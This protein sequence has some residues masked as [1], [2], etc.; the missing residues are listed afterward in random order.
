MFIQRLTKG[1]VRIVSIFFSA[2]SVKSLNRC[3][4]TNS[5]GVTSD[6]AAVVCRS[7]GCP[8]GRTSPFSRALEAL[9]SSKHRNYNLSLVLIGDIRRVEAKLL[10][11]TAMSTISL[12]QVV[13][14]CVKIET[15]S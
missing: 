13:H 15:K 11:Q 5:P 14:R 10:G 7:G 6:A 4:K 2:R 12:R 9:T 8:Q 1:S 3:L